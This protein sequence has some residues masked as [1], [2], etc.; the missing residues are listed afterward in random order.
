MH[1]MTK[2]SKTQTES[3]SVTSFSMNWTTQ[4]DNCHITQQ[5]FIKP[6]PSLFQQG[7]QQWTTWGCGAE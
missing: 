5:H 1:N 2:T 3:Q 7:K 6:K 4:Y